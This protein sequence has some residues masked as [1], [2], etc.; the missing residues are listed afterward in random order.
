MSRLP[1]L[2]TAVAVALGCGPR[3]TAAA[4]SPNVVLIISDD[5]GWPDYGFMGHEHVRTPHLDRLASQSL[6]F[7]RGY[8]P[9][10]LCCPSLATMITGRYPHQHRITSNDPPIPPGMKPGEF[11]KSQAFRDGREVMNRHLEAVP[12]LPRLL[13]RKGYV[14]LQT[15]KWWQGDFRRGGFTHGMT[16]GQRHGDDGL[17]IGRKTMQPIY[18]FVA[19]ARKQGKPFFIWYAPMLP[20]TPHNPPERL[21]ARYRENAPSL[22]VARYWAMVEW[23]DETCG[24]LLDF[25]DREK[26]AENTLVIYVADNG[27]IQDPGGALSVRSKRTPYDAGVRTPVLVRWPGRVKPRMSDEFATSLD[28]APTVLAAAGLPA[29]GEM[30]GLNLLDE[31]AVTARKTIYGACFTHNAVDLNDP[32]RNVRHR[33]VIDGSW[34]LIVPHVPADPDGPG[35]PELYDL[36]ADPHE[37]TNRLAAEPAAA[38]ALRRKLD[39]WWNPK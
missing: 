1:V 18:D 33:W 7:K 11:Q 14:S 39:A 35:E 13:V 25:L 6:T 34:K 26:L 19:D 16:K 12:T 4:G 27:W 28:I 36:A 5:H 9:S 37:K 23:F 20:H 38:A 3:L 32:A 2:L 21:L 17:D 31:A 22:P 30:P 29:D 24:Q 15:G 10:S 8:V